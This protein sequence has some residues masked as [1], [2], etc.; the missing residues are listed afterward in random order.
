MSWPN[1]AQ[2]AGW[3]AQNCESR[4]EGHA[5]TAHNYGGRWRAACATDQ[6][7]NPDDPAVYDHH[8]HA[9]ALD[10]ARNILTGRI[11]GPN[12]TETP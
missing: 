6:C 7:I 9:D 2:R 5:P 8:D 10:Q 12:D 1:P 11:H 4:F 3:F